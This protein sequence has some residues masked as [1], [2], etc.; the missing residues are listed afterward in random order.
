VADAWFGNKA[1]IRTSL[2]VGMQA[3]LSMKKNKMKTDGLNR[4]TWVIRMG[5][6]KR[7]KD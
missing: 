1:M 5:G 7:G 3:I 6:R 4:E 2:D